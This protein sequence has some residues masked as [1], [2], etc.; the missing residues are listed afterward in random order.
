[1]GGPARTAG[2]RPLRGEGAGA[3]GFLANR[4]VF[5]GGVRVPYWEFGDG[6]LLVYVP[7]LEDGLLS[8]RGM[9]W[10]LRWL[11]RWLA[12]G[13]RVL[14]LGRREVVPPG[15]PVRQMAAD[16]VA[17]LRE[18]GVRPRA[19][20]GLSAGGLV[21]RWM[22]SDFPQACGA[23]VLLSA[24]LNGYSPPGLVRF[25]EHL[26]RLAHTASWPEVF[27]HALSVYLTPGLRRRWR[28]GL[29]V[30]HRL[31]QPESPERLLRHLQAFRQ[32]PEPPPGPLSVPV[33]VV[34]G[35]LDSMVPVRPGAS[36]AYSRQRLG[37]ARLGRHVYLAGQHSAVLEHRPV[38]AQELKRFLADAARTP[39]RG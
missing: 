26:A 38:V 8:R 36:E 37:I 4:W 21:A 27:E 9:A 5:A 30:L 23:L 29:A 31:G 7:G 3:R 39:G 1:M 35:G 22:A 20:V 2:P 18:L 24:P 13:Y 34:N 25:F 32:A 28:L 10:A 19:V 11:A 16:S 33:L 15:F 12:P 17:A 14:A 6:P